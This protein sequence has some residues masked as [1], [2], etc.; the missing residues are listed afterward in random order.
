MYATLSWH[1]TALENEATQ[2]TEIHRQNAEDRIKWV[3]GSSITSPDCIAEARQSQRENEREEQDLAAQKVTAWWTKIMGVAALIGMGLS[4]VGVW[5]VKTTFD[6]TRRSN[7]IA[8][9]S[10][11]HQFSADLK[12]ESAQIDIMDSAV[13]LDMTII[14]SGSTVAH[15]VKVNGSFVVYAEK[16]GQFLPQSGPDVKSRKAT[17]NLNSLTI[18]TSENS[19]CLIWFD[20]RDTVLLGKQVLECFREGKNALLQ[21]NLIVSWEDIFG[22]V[23][24][25]GARFSIAEL[26]QP[27]STRNFYVKSQP[28]RITHYKP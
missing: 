25:V 17:A 23:R 13:M 3:C 7:E 9:A 24:S 11:A 14:N 21:A 27:K 10:A 22:Q 20:E 12:V 28:A 19:N 5:L 26:K 8:L 16:E 4:A 6:E 1:S 18:G 2:R 15:N